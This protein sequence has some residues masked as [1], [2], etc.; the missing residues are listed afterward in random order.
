MDCVSAGAA[1]ISLKETSFFLL[2]FTSKGW[3]W[4]WT[5]EKLKNRSE[6]VMQCALASGKFAKVG[7]WETEIESLIELKHI[8]NIFK[9]VQ[10]RKSTPCGKK[11]R[12]SSPVPV[13]RSLLLRSVWNVEEDFQNTFVS[14]VLSPQ[15]NKNGKKTRSMPTK[16]FIFSLAAPSIAEMFSHAEKASFCFWCCWC[17]SRARF[18]K[19]FPRKKKKPP[20][21]L[22][23]RNWALEG[24]AR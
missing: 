20:V 1:Q 12:F 16:H 6:G 13:C 23:N 10:R 17:G 15:K 19:A 2:T 18:Y 5:E 14:R 4:H 22:I 11:F 24:R 8:E 7:K 21:K 9:V 3:S